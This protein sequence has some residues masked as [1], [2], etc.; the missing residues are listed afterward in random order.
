MTLSGAD[1]VSYIEVFLLTALRHCFVSLQDPSQI[2][3]YMKVSSSGQEQARDR[4]WRR[5]EI[6]KRRV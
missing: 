4:S 1:S 3:W 2:I 5:E 6:E